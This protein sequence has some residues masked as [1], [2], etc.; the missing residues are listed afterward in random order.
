MRLVV[1]SLFLLL[2]LGLT[3]AAQS[4]RRVAPTP[5]PDASSAR[6]GEP[7]LSYSESQPSRRRYTPPAGAVPIQSAVLAPA[8]NSTA[9]G[10]EDVVKVETNLVTIPV[11]VF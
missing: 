2:A 3:A 1:L 7:A 6:S 9:S 5:T 11:S 4:G 8:A 10:D